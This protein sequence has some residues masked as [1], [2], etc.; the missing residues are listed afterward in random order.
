MW[1]S[2]LQSG[3]RF[4]FSGDRFVIENIGSW[5]EYRRCRQHIKKLMAVAITE[6]TMKPVAYRPG[7]PRCPHCQKYGKCSHGERVPSHIMQD[8]C[9]QWVENESLFF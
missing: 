1:Q 4:S 8:G 5:A 3:L 2:L 7:L 6:Q 9:D